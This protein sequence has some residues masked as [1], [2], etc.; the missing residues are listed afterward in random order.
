MTKYNYNRN[1]FLNEDGLSYYLLGAY[2]TDG[3]V[4]VNG[5]SSWI[6]TL[7]SK[8]NDWLQLIRQNICPEMKMGQGNQVKVLA[9][10]D[11]Q[12]GDW[13]IS[14]GCVPRKSTILRFPDIPKLYIADFIRGCWDGDGCISSYKKANGQTAY[15]SYLCSASKPFLEVV[16]EHL[17]NNNINC[18]ICAV[19]KKPC[20]INGREVIPQHPHYRLCLGGRATYR[21]VQLLYYPKHTLS[22]PRKMDKAN[23]VIEYYQNLA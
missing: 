22:M 5:K 1:A 17:K 23:T 8:D 11:K 4:Q 21:L 18:S 15:S 6:I 3:C 2:M 14:K 20:K 9:I 7:S 12:I 19:N 16:S 13:F 10:T